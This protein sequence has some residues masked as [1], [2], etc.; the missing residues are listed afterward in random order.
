M[1]INPEIKGKWVAALRSGEY[2]QGRG[3][4]RKKSIGGDR[5]CC[6][7]VLCD[8]YAKEKSEKTAWVP[9]DVYNDK[10]FSF[11]NHGTALPPRS[12][13]TW[14]GLISDLDWGDIL[15]KASRTSG[16]LYELNDSGSS[17]KKIADYIEAQ[18]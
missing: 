5:F 12:V 13:N 4:L 10:D 17:F 8:I 16:T 7:G 14:A 15:I 9:S 2:R 1:K 3:S 6:L 11:G 18:L